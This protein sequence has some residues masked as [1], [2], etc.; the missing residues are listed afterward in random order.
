M[1]FLL[2]LLTVASTAGGYQLI[3]DILPAA[4]P[5]TLEAMSLRLCELDWIQSTNTE[6]PEMK[7]KEETS[8]LPTTHTM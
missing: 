1:P 3:L 2:N 8:G 6:R 7:P 5:E 4:Q